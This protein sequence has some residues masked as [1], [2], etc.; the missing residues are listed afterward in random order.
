MNRFLVCFLFVISILL[1][2]NSQADKHVDEA[3][4]KE[5]KSLR[6]VSLAGALTETV[7]SLGKTEQIVGIDITSTYPEEQTAALPK[8]GH[9]SSV[10]SEG[11]LS[12]KPDLVLVLKKGLRQELVQ[13]LNAAGVKVLIIDQEFSIK[14]TKQLI[15]TLANVLDAQAAADSLKSKID[16]DL[17]K[18][19]PLAQPK[20]AL[21]IYARGA[22]N[23]SVGGKG[24]AVAEL[25]EIAGGENVAND[26][27]A[28]K[29]LTAEAMVKANPEIILFFQ[30]ALKSMGGAKA[31]N[32][33]PAIAQ[34]KAGAKETFL[35]M[36]GLFMAGFGP[37]VGEAALA[38][39]QAFQKLGNE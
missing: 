34:T 37:R 38:L 20:Q 32:Q 24:T 10:N 31:L 25:I 21:F 18:M 13:Q 23:M 11:V 12:L 14:G 7:Y 8:L 1:A 19:K 16:A 17:A 39:N 9:I 4:V 28:Y 27:E 33:I 2:C 29:P 6:I 3:E 22:G 5:K 15:D 36:D 26:F 35:G 30:S